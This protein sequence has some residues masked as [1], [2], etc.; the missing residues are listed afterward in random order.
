[1]LPLVGGKSPPR[2]AKGEDGGS[3]SYTPPPGQNQ[4]I[5]L[6]FISAKS[7]I[8]EIALSIYFA[9]RAIMNLPSSNY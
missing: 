5:W 7:W 9:T 1:M 8:S 2:D 6:V 3:W 4:Q